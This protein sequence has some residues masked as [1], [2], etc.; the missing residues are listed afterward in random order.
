[1]QVQVHAMQAFI[2]QYS[3]SAELEARITTYLRHRWETIMSDRK[4]LVDA[5]ELLDQLPRTMRYETVESLTMETLAKVPLFARVEEGF[6]HALTQSGTELPKG[7][8]GALTS[9]SPLRCYR[10]LTAVALA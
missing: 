6:M 8:R 5:A 7:R 2:N 3:F 9:D 1:M 10:G 4:E